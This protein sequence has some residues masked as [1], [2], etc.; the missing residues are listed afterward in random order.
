MFFLFSKLLFFLLTPIFWVF[1]LLCIALFSK[2]VTRKKKFVVISILLLYLFSNKFLFNEV[3]RKWDIPLTKLEN[4]GNYDYA[5]VLGGF[6]SFDTTYAK[7]KFSE[8][9]DRMW[10]GLQLYYQ[11][12]VR[13]IL[14][15]GGSG[16]VLHQ[17]ETEA[18]KV[19]AFLLSINVPDSDIIME[20]TSRNTHENAVFTQAWLKKHDP[21]ARCLL[22]TSA[23]H[24]RR[25]MGCYKKEGINVT[26]YSSHQISDMRKF[27]YDILILPQA[28][29]L[30]Y[31]NSLIKE[32]VG[33]VAYKVVGYL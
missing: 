14:I 7:V 28:I 19:K 5:V 22:V 27:D 32:W 25:A 30:D 4:V 11:K 20:M 8:A 12:K 6:S 29:T 3:E 1:S 17:D 10:Q 23:A 18:D 33:Y 21:G 2:Q 15:S 13:K 31:W 9:S 24:M 26:P 16:S